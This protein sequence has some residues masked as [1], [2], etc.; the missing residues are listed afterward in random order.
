MNF[1][2]RAKF[3]RPEQAVP[4]DRFQEQQRRT[5]LASAGGRTASHTDDLRSFRQIRDGAAEFA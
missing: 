4:R 2:G 5:R 1:A 3:A